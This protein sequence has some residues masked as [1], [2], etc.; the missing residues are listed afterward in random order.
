LSTPDILTTIV[1]LIVISLMIGIMALTAKFI[2]NR[3]TIKQKNWWIIAHLM[4]VIVYFSG[5]LGTLLLTNMTITKVTDLN[6]IHAAH[7]FS[8]YCDWFLII[9]GAFGSLITGVWLALRT[10]WG[11]TKFH[12]IVVKVL[13]NIGA[14]LYGGTLM[15]IWFDRTVD[16]SSDAQVNFLN[17]TVYLYNRQMLIIGTLISLAIL[18]FLVIISVLKPWGKRKNIKGV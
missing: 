17:N 8:K 13:G 4:F 9:P 5:L 15:R 3:L 18:F 1:L 16:L 6:Q 14:I 10:N 7:I 12:W 11:L 2:T